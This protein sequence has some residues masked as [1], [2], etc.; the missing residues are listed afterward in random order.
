M[1]GGI[2]HSIKH[3]HSTMLRQTVGSNSSSRE[4]MRAA[5]LC[6][7]SQTTD[8]DIIMVVP[9]D[10]NLSVLRT[11]L[12][13]IGFNRELSGNPTSPTVHVATLTF[14]QPSTTPPTSPQPKD[15]LRH[16]LKKKADIQNCH[17]LYLDDMNVSNT[18]PP[19][20]NSLY[21]EGFRKRKSTHVGMND[22]TDRSHEDNDDDIADNIV[23]DRTVHKLSEFDRETYPFQPPDCQ[24]GFAACS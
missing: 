16:H 8:E 3:P 18:R 15:L 19:V 10:Y 22:G 11:Q 23:Y 6:P 13:K 14:V 21:R 2:L 4:G 17:V 1:G 5:E 7:G 9:E 24:G 20:V 12:D